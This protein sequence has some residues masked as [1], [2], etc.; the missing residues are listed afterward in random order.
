M[1]ATK[2]VYLSEYT[3]SGGRFTWS[4]SDDYAKTRNECSVG[5][6]YVPFLLLLLFWFSLHRSE[7]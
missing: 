1:G 6:I 4:V 5:L 7:Q 3:G 2:P